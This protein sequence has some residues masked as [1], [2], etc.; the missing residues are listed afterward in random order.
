LETLAGTTVV[1]SRPLVA[2]SSVTIDGAAN[3]DNHLTVDYQFGGFFAIPGGITFNGGTG[4]GNDG[5]LI[6]GNTFTDVT[7]TFTS[8]Q[9]GSLTV[10]G[11]GIAYTAVNQSVTMTGK[12]DHLT[13][14]LPDTGNNVVLE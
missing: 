8:G 14:K 9:D 7:H 13:L 12:S 1:D 6:K 5:L 3:V 4:A 2:V 10:D 11:T